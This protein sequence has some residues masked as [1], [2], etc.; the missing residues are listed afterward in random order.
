MDQPLPEQP[1]TEESR[2]AESPPVDENGT[3][4]LALIVFAISALAFVVYLAFGTIQARIWRFGRLNFEDRTIR[5]VWSYFGDRLP[6]LPGQAVISTLYWLA[7]AVMVIGT[8]IGLWLF[9]ATPDDD[10]A[11]DASAASVEH[12]AP[13]A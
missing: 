3:V 6:E 5:H 10:P 4:N 12:P 7:L 1:V 2:I 11:H 8:V 13:H 9:L